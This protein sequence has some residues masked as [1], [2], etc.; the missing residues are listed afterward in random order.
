MFG[1]DIRITQQTVDNAMC[2]WITLLCWTSLGFADVGRQYDA[3]A[4]VRLASLVMTS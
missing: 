2:H 1:K 4:L 3:V